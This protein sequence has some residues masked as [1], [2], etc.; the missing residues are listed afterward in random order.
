MA[1][2]TADELQARQRAA[3]QLQDAIQDGRLKQ[4]ANNRFSQNKQQRNDEYL[5]DKGRAAP[6]FLRP[7]DVDK[8]AEYGTDQVLTM[9]YGNQGQTLTLTADD[10]R[11]FKNNV[12]ILQSQYKGGITAKQVIDRSLAI[13]IQRS[14]EEIKLAVPISQKNGEVHFLTNASDKNGALNH[15]VHVQ[16]LAFEAVAAS[17]NAQDKVKN[18]LNFGKLKFECDCGRH[19]FWYRYIATIGNFGYGRQ[20]TGYP[21]IRNRALIGLAC[22]HVLR[23]MQYIRSPMGVLYLQK[24][25][26]KLQAKDKQ[27]TK[28]QQRQNRTQSQLEKELQQLSKQANTIKPQSLS[29]KMEAAARR[30]AGKQ[31]RNDA[32]AKAQLESLINQLGADA[33]QA[34]LNQLKE[35]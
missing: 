18:S 2:F 6:K 14:N 22:K 33:V 34:M 35:K 10:L 13:D 20:E 29:K 1:K 17:P 8:Y 30:E 28:N 27:H 3:K 12:E 5:A 25:I 26:A 11:A 15:H 16:F 31:K 4:K 32:K 7:S 9:T 23:V 24:E 19:N 21:K